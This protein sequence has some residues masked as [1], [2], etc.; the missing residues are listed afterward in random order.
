MGGHRGWQKKGAGHEEDGVNAA[1]YETRIWEEGREKARRKFEAE[2]NKHACLEAIGVY[3]CPVCGAV[4]RNRGFELRT[5]VSRMGDVRVSRRCCTCPNGHGGFAPLDNE[6]RLHKQFTVGI[7]Q[8]ICYT[9]AKESFEGAAETVSV[10]SGVTIAPAQIREVAEWHGRNIDAA[11][12]EET[13]RICAPTSRPEEPE[14]PERMYVEV[15]GAHLPKRGNNWKECRVGVMFDTPPNDRRHRPEHAFYV[16]GVELMESFGERLF[17]QAYKRGVT[18]AG[19]VIFLGD[20]NKGNWTVADTY[21]SHAVQILDFYH[22]YEHI[23]KARLLK[24]REDDKAG[25]WWARAQ[26]VRLLRSWW[27]KFAEGFEELPG[28]TKKQRAE[29]ARALN[30]FLNNKRR[31]NYREYR[32][33]GFYIGSGMVESGCKLVVTRRM[34]I[35]G[36]RWNDEGSDAM[37]QVRAAYLNGAF[38]SPFSN[39]STGA[40]LKSRG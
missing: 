23:S 22:A 39:L 7:Q 28:R 35:S 15:D 3:N 4:M 10:L 36:A 29:R 21:F 11:Q 27:D 9:S 19:E 24:W 31:M 18:T 17:A 6:L 2:L 12:K 38:R 13:R 5:I 40:I 37:V 33:L 16:A 14:G 20:G 26:R 25:T 1:F 8:W 32:A 30:Y 34:K